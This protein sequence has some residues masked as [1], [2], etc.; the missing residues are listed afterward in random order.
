MAASFA[1]EQLIETACE[2]TGLDDFGADTFRVG[3]DRLA[4]GLHHEA[5]LNEVGEVMAPMAVLGHLTNRLQVTDWHRRHPEIGAGDVTPP[6]VMIGMGR[7]GSTILHDLFGQDPANRVPRTWEVDHPCPPP[8]AATY[9]TDPRIAESQAGIDL[10]YEARPELRSMHPMG[11]RLGQ[12]CIVITAGEFA[13]A[14]FNSQFRLP[15]Y[16][17]WVTSEADMAPAYRWHRQF[18][19]LLQWHNPGGRWVLKTG[20]HLWALPAL[21]AEYPD[22]LIVQTHRDP[23]RIIASLS[24]LFAVVQAT[25]SD[26]VSMAD[27]A[28]EWADPVL[29]ALDRSVTA[30]EE[31]IISA[32]QVVDVHYGAFM[33]D[34]F[35]T[36]RSIYE[37][38]GAELTPDAEARMRHFLD[39]NRADK[40]GTHEY[41]FADT[42]LDAGAVRDR[43]RRYAEYFDVRFEPAR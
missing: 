37:R 27:V 24:S 9:E 10:A 13:S 21:L 6:I 5:R 18:L 1:T 14:I 11:A 30:R 17:R 8:E 23:L 28:G 15:S 38:L 20:A 25:A 12:E 35:R 40:H 34:P 7:T 26:G 43:A 22:A 19:Q 29:D 2:Q 31:G 3:L 33:A 41:S 32:D 4:D 16:L 42:G 39:E 36:I